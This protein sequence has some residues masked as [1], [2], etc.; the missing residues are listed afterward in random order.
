MGYNE[1][2]IRRIAKVAFEAAMSRNKKIMLS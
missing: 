1:D 2:E